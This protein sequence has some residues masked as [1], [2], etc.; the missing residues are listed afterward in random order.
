MPV[1]LAA[2]DLDKSARATLSPGDPHEGA[3]RGSPW[4]IVALKLLGQVS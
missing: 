3:R 2:Q 4:L 1:V